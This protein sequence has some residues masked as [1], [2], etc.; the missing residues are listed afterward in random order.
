MNPSSKA[1]LIIVNWNSG[2][3]LERCLSSLESQTIKPDE[4]IVIDNGS[5]DS[6]VSDIERNHSGVKF[7]RLKKNIG[8]AAANNFG[9]RIA[10]KNDW[11]ALLNPDAFP[12]PTW[13]A[14][15]LTAARKH[16]QYSFFGSRM[17]STTNPDRL[18]GLGDVYHT[19]GLAWRHKHGFLIDSKDKVCRE[20]FSPCAAAAIYKWEAFFE[21]GGFAEDY[22]CYLEDVDLGYRLRLLGHRCLYV[23]DAVVHHVSYSTTGRHSDF[24]IYHAHRN[25]VWTYLKDMPLPLFLF[26][27]PQHVILNLCS[28]F[29]FSLH[30]KA[31]AVFR[32]KWDAIKY[33]PIVWKQRQEIQAKRKVGSWAL[34]RL[35]ARG[36]NVRR[37]WRW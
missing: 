7:I 35:M 25:L 18:D 4:T 11:I 24:T 3:H 6:S 32:A 29:W 26:Y 28:L 36:V 1:S 13:L 15:L 9:V 27:L 20:I 23:P 14:D 2:K 5:H 33:I 30:G 31:G 12:E 17:L 21:A 10:E 16:P 8:F 34:R 22:F 19:S 37:K